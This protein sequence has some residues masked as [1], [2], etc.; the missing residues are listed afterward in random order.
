MHRHK[1]KVGCLSKHLS[2]LLLSDCI[3]FVPSVSFADHQFEL[4]VSHGLSQLLSDFFEVLESDGFFVLKSEQ[5]ERTL[6]F[7]L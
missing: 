1:S 2:E 7:L 5:L 4:V 6:D 3:G